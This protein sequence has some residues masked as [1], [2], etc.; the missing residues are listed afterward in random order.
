MTTYPTRAE[1]AEARAAKDRVV[2]VCNARRD[3]A[4]EAEA[5]LRHAR[6]EYALKQAMIDLDVQRQRAGEV[7]RP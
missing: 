1:L 4:L 3:R 6:T 5:Q 7:K 2:E